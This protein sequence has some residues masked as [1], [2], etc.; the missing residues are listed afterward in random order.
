MHENRLFVQ[1]NWSVNVLYFLEHSQF[2]ICGLKLGSIF[3]RRN[4]EIISLEPARDVLYKQ[5]EQKGL[6]LNG[7]DASEYRIK[8]LG[9]KGI[10]NG[11]KHKFPATENLHRLYDIF[12]VD[13]LV[14]IET[15]IDYIEAIY[16]GWGVI[17]VCDLEYE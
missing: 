1:T 8:L 17:F 11:A 7:G 6:V 10:A 13:E 9:H 14:L 2:L 15:W 4:Q 5:V 12:V 3:I 16:H